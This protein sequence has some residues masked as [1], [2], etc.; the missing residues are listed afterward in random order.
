MAITAPTFTGYTAGDV[1]TFANMITAFQHGTC[2]L[3]DGSL[4]Q[5]EADTMFADLS[6]MATGLANAVAIGDLAESP[7]KEESKVE[8]LKTTNYVIEGKR[9]N[10]VEI[11]LAGLTQDR[12]D[13]LEQQLNSTERTIIL[14][15]SSG[16]DALIFSGM[17]WSY[18]R[19]TEFNKLFTATIATE[20]AGV[21]GSKYFLYKSIP[22]AA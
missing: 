20:Y 19:S 2:Y 18:E 4:S 5:A 7:G 10:T 17:R 6:V 15:S 9:T 12:K 8:K 3:A 16:T 11:S 22:A 14:V 1:T 21:T 13:W